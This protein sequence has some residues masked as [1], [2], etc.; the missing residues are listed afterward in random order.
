[1]SV[2]DPDAEPGTIVHVVHPLQMGG[3]GE[4]Q[5][6]PAAVAV[7][8]KAREGDGGTEDYYSILGVSRSAS[9]E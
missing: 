4:H 7:A 9:T 2:N 6:R 8:T 1:M 5:L 3:N